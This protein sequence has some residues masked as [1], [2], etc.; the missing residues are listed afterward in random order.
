MTIKTMNSK[1]R[2]QL[3]EAGW[4]VGNAEEFLELTEEEKI[5][6][7]Q[8][9]QS[10]QYFEKWG[11]SITNIE[12]YHEYQKRL[13]KVL[14]QLNEMYPKVERYVKDYIQDKELLSQVKVSR[15]AEVTFVHLLEYKG[16][17]GVIEVDVEENMLC[18]RVIDIEDVVTFKAETV[19]QVKI[20]FAKS[21]DNYLKFCQE[22]IE[23]GIKH[24]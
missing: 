5:T 23:E 22:L 3:E 18:G 4:K 9:L 19:E 15:I 20:E 10:K 24:D 17:C 21:V 11:V 7:S 2:Q 13:P 8:L 12:Q 6:V 1:K 14:L 16:Y